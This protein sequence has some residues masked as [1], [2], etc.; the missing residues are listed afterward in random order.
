MLGPTA[1]EPSS[2]DVAAALVQ[3]LSAPDP[4]TIEGEPIDGPRLRPIYEARGQA[5]LW[6]GEDD[7]DARLGVL[8]ATVSDASTHGLDPTWYHVAAITQRRSSS[9]PRVQ[10]ELDLLASDA[11]IQYASD[12]RVGRQAPTRRSDEVDVA[13]R[14]MDASALVAGAV[15][16]PD[17]KA[18]LAGLVPQGDDYRRLCELLAR[19]RK[20]LTDGGLPTIPTGTGPA[21]LA[22]VQRFLVLTGDLPPEV[23]G[24]TPSVESLKPGVAAFQRRHGLAADGALGTATRAAMNVPVATRIEQ[25]VANLERARWLPDDLGARHVAVNIPDFT[26]QVVDT[27]H[28]VLEMPVVVGKT[29]WTTPIVSSQIT[30]LSFNPTWTVPPNIARRDML[31]RVRR[32]SSYLTGIGLDVYARGAGHRVDPTTVDWSTTSLGS[33]MLRQPAGPR[34]PLGRVKFEFPNVNGVYLHDSPSRRYFS[35]PVRAFSHGCV[36]V[37]RALDLAWELLRDTPEWPPSRR[38]SLLRDWKTRYVRLAAPV[39]VHIL[40]RTAWVDQSGTAHFR[41]D[42]YGRD[43]RL[44]EAMRK[45]R[46]F[47]PPPPPP[48]PAPLPAESASVPAGTEVVG[49]PTL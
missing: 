11:L 28:P 8:V 22:V 35:A 37:G 5:P 3:V 1:G 7:R 12:V 2:G 36:R 32:D 6:S 25:I 45:K 29:D 40:Y 33:F 9:D 27:G 20:L 13:P 41:T 43:R 49:Q 47:L 19:H 15:A 16:A 4:V 34:N 21:T 24:A 42:I 14:S 38:Q 10:A 26:L 30:Q 46:V 48:M 23:G 44:A 39:P 18:Y 31:H 17:L